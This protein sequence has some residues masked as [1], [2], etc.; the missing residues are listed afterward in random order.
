MVTNVRSPNTIKGFWNPITI[1]AY[2]ST[3][4]AQP[5]PYFILMF[6]DTSH[7]L[8]IEEKQL[9]SEEEL[10]LL[11]SEFAEEDMEL[12]EMGMDEYNEVLLTEDEE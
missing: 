11:F 3:A 9:V 12:A 1:E 8:V 4:I 5:T 10:R 2:A 6:P 7:S